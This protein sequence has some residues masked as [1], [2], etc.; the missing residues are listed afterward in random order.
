VSLRL[1]SPIDVDGAASRSLDLPTRR[2]RC[3]D[4]DSGFGAYD[5]PVLDVEDLVTP[6]L[7]FAD[8][9]RTS[10]PADLR[11]AWQTEIVEPHRDL[12]DS[13]ADWVPPERADAALPVLIEEAGSWGDALATAAAAARE[14]ERVLAGAVDIGET[15]PVTVLVGVGAANGWAAPVDGVPRLFLA[16]ERLPGAPYDVVLA[17]HELVHLLHLRSGARSWSQDRVDALLFHEGLATHVTMSLIPGISA[18]GHLWCDEDHGT[19]LSACAEREPTLRRELLA[20]LETTNCDPW[21][22]A[23]P[24]QSTDIP[25]RAGYW[26]GARLIGELAR[27][28]SLRDLLD[29]DLTTATMH[30][31]R[32]LED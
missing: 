21:F 13:I 15:V 11:V 4:A 12:F 24:Q 27:T 19:W 31:R 10:P 18:S 17:L 7:A 25:V 22:S 16:V 2:C 3:I 20:T 14:A 30:L 23:A 9:A 32:M 29:L 1:E 26:L 5:V 6:F 28:T 8:R